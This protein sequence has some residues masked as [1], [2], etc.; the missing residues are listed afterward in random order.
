MLPFVDTA[1]TARDMD[2]IRAALGDA[3][4]TYLGL[5]YGTF[6]GQ[7]YAHLFATHVRALAVDAVVDPL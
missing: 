5:F 2:V 6:L 3:K 1:S 4:L 7:T